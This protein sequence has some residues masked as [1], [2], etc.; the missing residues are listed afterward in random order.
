MVHLLSEYIYVVWVFR[1]RV[2]SRISSF[3][4][5]RLSDEGVARE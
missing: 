5:G 3:H 1:R 2:D 4:C